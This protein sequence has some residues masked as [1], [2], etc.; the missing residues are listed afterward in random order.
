MKRRALQIASDNE[1]SESSLSSESSHL[2]KK[3][4][5][6][7]QRRKSGSTPGNGPSSGALIDDGA[8]PS[9]MKK[10]PR[11]PSRRAKKDVK[12]PVEVSESDDESDSDEDGMDEADEKME[13]ELSETKRKQQPQAGEETL[14]LAI[15]EKV[16]DFKPGDHDEDPAVP[17][18]AVKSQEEK[19]EAKPMITTMCGLICI[20]NP[21]KLEYLESFSSSVFDV[22]V[23][24][25]VSSKGS[26]LLATAQDPSVPE[27]S[28]LIGGQRHNP[29]MASLYQ[30]WKEKSVSLS[31]TLSTFTAAGSTQVDES[32]AEWNLS[33]VWPHGGFPPISVPG[34]LLRITIHALDRGRI[35]SG[36]AGAMIKLMDILYP[37][38]SALTEADIVKHIMSSCVPKKYVSQIAPEQP[39]E[40]LPTLHA[41]QKRCVNWLLTREGV[42][43][44]T[45]GN[46]LSYQEVISSEDQKLFWDH[47][48][49]FGGD[50]FYL[51]RITGR[52]VDKDSVRGP[53]CDLSKIKGGVLADEMGLGKTIEMLSLILLHRPSMSSNPPLSFEEL[54][55][56]FSPK[57]VNAESFCFICQSHGTRIDRTNP[58]TK[59]CN[60]CEIYAH[61]EC[62]TTFPGT[63]CPVC[64]PKANEVMESEGELV[65]SSATLIITPLSIMSQW[66]SEI[67]THAPSLNY[68]GDFT[69]KDLMDYDVVVTT[70]ETLRTEV[71]LARGDSQRSRRAARV[72]ERRTSPLTKIKWWRLCLDEAQ[73]VESTVANASEMA[74]RIPRFHQ[75][76]VTGTPLPHLDVSDLDGLLFFLGIEPFDSRAQF[77]RLL[78]PSCLRHARRLFSKIIHRTTKAIASKDLTLPPQIQTYVGL[79]FSPVERRYYDDLFE[80]CR[81]ELH[82]LSRRLELLND[83][84]EK[85]REQALVLVKMKS[86]L[87]HLRQTCCHPQVGDRNKRVL[88]GVLK[89]IDEVLKLMYSQ[90]V[91]SIGGLERQIVHFRINRAQ[92]FEFEKDFRSA[93]EIYDSCLTTINRCL[94]TSANDS[95]VESDAVGDILLDNGDPDYSDEQTEEAQKRASLTAW[96]EIK[97]RVVFFIACCHN[98][99]KETKEEE[100]Y[101][102]EA[103]AIRKEI[104]AIPLTIVERCQVAMTSKIAEK[105][106]ESKHAK[107]VLIRLPAGGLMARSIM[108][109]FARLIKCLG[110]QWTNVIAIWRQKIVE[111]LLAS[112]EEEVVEP[113]PTEVLPVDKPADGT[114][115]EPKK[116]SYAKNLDNQADLDNYLDVYADVLADRRQIVAGVTFLKPRRP[117]ESNLLKELQ[118]EREKYVLHADDHFGVYIKHIKAKIETT[119]LAVERDLMSQTVSVVN[120]RIEAELEV[121]DLLNNEIAMFRRVA[122]ARIDYFRHLQRISDGVTPPEP[123]TAPAAVVRSNFANEEKVASDSLASQSRRIAYLKHL[124]NE[125][126]GGKVSETA[127]RECVICRSD[128]DRGYMTF[129][130][131]LYCGEC[132]RFWVIKHNKCAVCNQKVK[133]NQVTSVSFRLFQKPEATAGHV[134]GNGDGLASPT[135]KLLAAST[136]SAETKAADTPDFETELV[137]KLAGIPTNGS[138][139]TKVDAIVRHLLYL[140][141]SDPG[142]KSLVFS[143]WEQVLH[144]LDAAFQSNRIKF[145]RMEGGKKAKD[146]IQ[147]FREDSSVEVF[148]LHAKS[149]SSGLTLVGATH[150]F[151]V[152]P[153]L[154]AGIELQA[155][156]RVHRIGQEKV[157]RVY[158]Y[159]IFDSVEERIVSL[160][161]KKRKEKQSGNAEAEADGVG[162]EM[163]LDIQENQESAY[164]AADAGIP[165][166]EQKNL[167]G[168]EVVVEKDL[169]WC[170]FGDEE[171]A[172]DA[173]RQPE[174]GLLEERPQEPQQPPQDLPM[175]DRAMAVPERVLTDASLSALPSPP[176]ETEDRNRDA[177]D[178]VVDVAEAGDAAPD[179]MEVDME[180]DTEVSRRPTV[181]SGST[182]RRSHHGR[183]G[184]LRVR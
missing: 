39:L 61:Y 53:V 160:V 62:R 149:Q 13:V 146:A 139:G 20:L 168:G 143:Q 18:P 27:F 132:T 116:D 52:C 89:S 111:L 157:T 82:E 117:I 175:G 184:G 98:S 16:P 92:T 8:A 3:R 14:P 151:L 178:E 5:K 87:L 164:S 183:I 10:G 93:L 133:R 12:Y 97:H 21:A 125:Q 182:G 1:E 91:S 68:S 147:R 78:M 142:C 46:A 103:E 70:Y 123:L 64:A 40:L 179:E 34:M 119:G 69:Y 108:D 115:P 100:Q 48:K 73:M 144:I 80:Q 176:V 106:I 43:L 105:K 72:Y 19:V 84:R 124:M 126:L 130:G 121:L 56:R 162:D 11:R 113:T 76:C 32:N 148:M 30:A 41:Y 74:R 131:H 51:D 7:I 101:Y 37:P 24:F 152:E 170:L 33:Q 26:Y 60:K 180:L 90:C 137:M 169:M 153:V 145:A 59:L 181:G 77:R 67:S 134:L 161:R 135:K 122:N 88:G 2:Q 85:E 79:D 83:P 38:K 172:G 71:H 154:N 17:M 128:F 6:T 120:K 31:G 165:L 129:C 29:I 42:R 66:T 25:S 9:I 44:G 163:D 166:L 177:V 118:A 81:D 109:E 86:W 159:T 155:I 95:G 4:S 138:F 58:M 174:P 107:A 23:T 136:T 99:L 171:M 110:E 158:R 45:H 15:T 141:E 102:K 28:Y 47:I 35:G 54:R 167:G 55:Q 173:L 75:W 104:L 94:Q 36:R 50:S 63:P 65:N 150:V 112:L 114:D 49:T 22:S 156:G 57:A 127:V 140:R 96:R